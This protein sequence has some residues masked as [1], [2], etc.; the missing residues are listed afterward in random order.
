MLKVKGWIKMYLANS[1]HKKA[2]MAKLIDFQTINI[3][4]EGTF[5]I[6]RVNFPEREINHDSLRN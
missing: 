1:G 3:T 2:R 6:M 5:L 4:K